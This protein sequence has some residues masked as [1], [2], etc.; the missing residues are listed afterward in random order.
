[1]SVSLA[2]A[3]PRAPRTGSGR[4]RTSPGSRFLPAENCC[5]CARRP[6]DVGGLVG[7]LE[8]AAAGTLYLAEELLTAY[9]ADEH[10]RFVE[11]PGVS[12]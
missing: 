7:L 1:V 4:A 9:V 10:G 3:H 8:I 12:T 11:V 6:A 5:S 2:C